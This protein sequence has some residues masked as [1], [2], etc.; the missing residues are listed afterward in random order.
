MSPTNT[1]EPQI[2]GASERP[3]S[4]V[5]ATEHV[6]VTIDARAHRDALARQGVAEPG[7]ILLHLE[8]IEAAKNPGSVY[9]VYVNLPED[10]DEQQLEEHH[11]GNLSFF[12]IEQAAA[13]RRDEPAHGMR[14]SM[15]ITDV[16]QTLKARGEWDGEHVQV[17]LQPLGLLPPAGTDV[18]PPTPTHED[19]PVHIG[20]VSVSY[21]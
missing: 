3:V 5:G 7:R 15:D 11:V 8:D 10:A 14:S 21:A 6:P 4:L 13:P 17:A 12:G 1:Q 16:A 9:G 19:L 18:A 2:V 20:R